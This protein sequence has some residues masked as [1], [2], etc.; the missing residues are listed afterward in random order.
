MALSGYF[1]DANLLLLLIVGNVGRGLIAKHRRL[2]DYT[3]EDYDTLL[4][5][6]ERVEYVFVT[7]N[8]LTETS[9]LLGQQGEPERSRFFAR[10]R[11]MIENTE[12]VVISS[13]TAASNANFDRLGLTD[14]ALFEAISEDT[15]LLTADLNLY[16]VAMKKSAAA[17]AA[18]SFRRLIN[19]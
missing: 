3:A 4:D 1:V 7:P 10:L 6:L 2:R 12:E 17:P 11:F 19:I 9:N 18:L 15:P 8:T 5:L 13:K 16:A 14:A